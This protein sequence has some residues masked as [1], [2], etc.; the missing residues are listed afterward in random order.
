M[1]PGMLT[2]RF[3]HFGHHINSGPAVGRSHARV[4]IALEE[5]GEQISVLF[6]LRAPRRGELLEDAIVGETVSNE[7]SIRT[8]IYKDQDKGLRVFERL[9]VEN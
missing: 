1:E 8:Q 2:S 7:T 4:G 3:V 9:G 6:A 5:R